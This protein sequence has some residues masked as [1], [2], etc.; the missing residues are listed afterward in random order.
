MRHPP[1]PARRQARRTP[2]AP[3]HRAHPRRRR[4]ARGL[5][6]DDGQY[7]RDLG[8]IATEGQIEIANAIYREI[9]PRELTY[10]ISLTIA[11]D[12]AWY[13]RADGRLDLPKLRRAFQA[14]FREHSEHWIERE[15]GLGRM[16]TDLLVIWPYGDGQVQK[17]VL[18]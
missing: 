3:G 5:P 2:R 4:R 6:T 14:F 11:Q 8:L 17:A 18:S 10:T 9:I 1:G 15:Y 12:P 7:V 13:I 16:R